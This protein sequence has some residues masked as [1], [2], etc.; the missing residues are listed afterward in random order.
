[1][2]K[3]KQIKIVMAIFFVFAILGVSINNAGA[4]T[5]TVTTTASIKTLTTDTTY[6]KSIGVSV[7]FT[8][9]IDIAVENVTSPKVYFYA[10]QSGETAIL[11]SETVSASTFV[12]DTQQTKGVTLYVDEESYA[13]QKLVADASIIVWAKI[14]NGTVTSA[15]YLDGDSTSVKYGDLVN[16]PSDGKDKSLTD[17]LIDNI[18]Y[19]A[20]IVLAAGVIG[21]AAI[22][23]YVKGR[24]MLD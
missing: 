18:F 3:Q 11:A 8:P 1:M 10:Q 6:E 19:I 9:I 5:L 16:A 23:F 2:Q 4:V 22:Y 15:N 13:G 24:E 12:N 20:L 17:T 7:K 14:Y 21:L